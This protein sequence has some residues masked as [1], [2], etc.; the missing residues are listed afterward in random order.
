MHLLRYIS[1]ISFI[2]MGLSGCGDND[3][4]RAFS[5]LPTSSSPVL[6][7]TEDGNSQFNISVLEQVLLSYSQDPLDSNEEAGVLL[8]REEEKFAHDVYQAMANLYGLPIFTNIATSEAT[9]TEAMRLLLERYQLDDPTL[10]NGMGEFTDITLQSLYFMLVDEGA[11]SLTDALRVGVLI[12][13][14]D[15]FDL[16]FLLAA[17]DGNDDIAYVYANLQKG[18]RNHLRAYYTQLVNQGASYTPQYLSQEVFDAIV[19]S[20][21][22][23]GTAGN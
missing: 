2:A 19:N 12:E 18:S 10:G 4:Q 1:F 7:I 16:E 17:L 9:H 23:R 14:L 11:V 22:E 13:E 15:I 21:I 20:P 3:R 6:D 8:M 5:P